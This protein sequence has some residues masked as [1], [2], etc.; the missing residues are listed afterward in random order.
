MDKRVCTTSVRKALICVIRKISAQFRC[1]IFTLRAFDGLQLPDLASATQVLEQ[2]KTTEPMRAHVHTHHQ[3][4]VQR[5]HYTPALPIRPLQ[6]Y[7]PR[8][9][10]SFC[11]SLHQ[12]L[13]WSDKN[14]REETYHFYN[15]YNAHDVLQ[16]QEN[17]LQ[18]PRTDGTAQGSSAAAAAFFAFSAGR[19]V[20]CER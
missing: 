8:H 11:C 4:L 16:Q 18:S 6:K 14:E 15:I 13:L 5:R 10:A 2:K 20:R 17:I 1:R 7:L 19:D 3:S 12:L 9:C